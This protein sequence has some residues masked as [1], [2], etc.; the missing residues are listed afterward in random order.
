MSAPPAQAGPAPEAGSDDVLAHLAQH[1]PHLIAKYRAQRSPSPANGLAALPANDPTSVLSRHFRDEE[2]RKLEPW[3]L[4]MQQHA[5]ERVAFERLPDAELK[6][7][8]IEAVKARMLTPEDVMVGAYLALG[9]PCDVSF[10]LCCLLNKSPRE[11]ILAHNWR[12][13]SHQDETWLT[14]WGKHVENFEFP[15]L[16]FGELRTLNLRL[17]QE[18]VAARNPRGGGGPQRLPTVFRDVAV[19]GE[20]YAVP[21]NEHGWVDLSEVQSHVVAIARDVEALKR[22]AR[23]RGSDRGSG[24]DRGG[25]GGGRSRGANRR[26]GPRGGDDDSTTAPAAASAAS[27]TAGF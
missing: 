15:L 2:E 21:V 7:Q 20:G 3:R 14:T 11:R 1:A 25:A 9:Q 17:M 8:Y 27:P 24:G 4:F 22:T 23:N 16:P 5:R 12:I 13:A 18:M 10:H 19:T 26:R 6:R